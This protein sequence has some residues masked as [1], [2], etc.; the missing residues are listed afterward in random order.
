M[1]SRK[2]LYY[3]FISFVCITACTNKSSLIST[4]CVPELNLTDFTSRNFNL[5]EL[6]DSIAI[7][8][9]SADYPF[10]G[11]VT[12][13]ASDRMIV[14]EYWRSG[15]FLYFNRDGNF[16]GKIGELGQGADEYMRSGLYTNY[17]QT[18]CLWDNVRNNAVVYSSIPTWRGLRMK[19]YNPDGSYRGSIELQHP[20]PNKTVNDAYMS[21]DNG[22][23]YLSCY[24]ST[25]ADGAAV[26]GFDKNGKLVFEIPN[27]PDRI[28]YAFE[29]ENSTNHYRDHLLMWGYTDT[30][31]EIKEGSYKAAYT[32][33]IEESMRRT[34]PM[35][36]RHEPIKPGELVPGIVLDTKEWL[37]IQASFCAP[38][39][40]HKYYFFNKAE[41]RLYGDEP[42][43]NDLGYFDMYAIPF[44]GYY[45]DEAKDEEWL[46]V[47][48]KVPE[49]L[50]K[51]WE[52]YDHP[53]GY[54]LMKR[55]NI[56]EDS[57]PILI[58]ARL[59]K[60]MTR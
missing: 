31:Y 45:Y 44:D 23:Y 4:V 60:K 8:E 21:F 47:T 38:P 1:R 29:K 5:S 25:V 39:I 59:K 43:Y 53:K 37:I 15:G 11:I 28:V 22:Y 16:L 20:Y 50:I 49:W 9:L 54:E 34:K 58:K 19:Y 57:N 13:I 35:T 26:L 56:T 14:E 3:F 42:P 24:P 33:F 12:Q 27:Q 6:V 30:I 32:W 48:A 10:M 2:F 46:Y 7:I 51:G 55:Y 17:G 40:K 52:K 18:H 41:Q 36:G